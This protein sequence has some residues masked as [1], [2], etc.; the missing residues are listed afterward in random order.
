M[1]PFKALLAASAIAVSLSAPVY[2]HGHGDCH[3]TKLHNYME[4]MKTDLK[5]LSFEI[6]SGNTENALTRIDS[7][8]Q[9][10]TLSRSETPYLLKEKTLSAEEL[11]QRMADYQKVIDDTSSV[12]NKLK[13]AVSEND[14]DS[15]KSLVKEVGKLR[16][17]GHRT[18]QFE[19]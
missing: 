6:R 18:F 17:I 3:D 16:K 14:Q 1:L 19:C 12:F 15:V 5:S 2:G 9:N 4:D 8:R 11:S 7:I 13:V 10:L